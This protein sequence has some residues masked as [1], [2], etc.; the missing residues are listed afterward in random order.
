MESSR[1]KKRPRGGLR[2]R[3]KR[4]NEGIE[5]NNDVTSA[6]ALL[7]LSLFEWGFFSPQRVQQIAE[8][9][10]R[11]IKAAAEDPSILKNL[12]TLANLGTKGKHSN[13]I[14][15][16]L[17]SKVEHVPA[18]PRPFSAKIPLKGFPNSMQY[19]LL[20]HEMFSCIYHN[21]KNL[22][23]TA[24]VPSVDR[25]KKF[26]RSMRLHPS[27]QGHPM[28]ADDFWDAQTVPLA[29][30]GDGVPITGIGKVWSRVKTNY[31]WYSLLGHGNTASMLMWIW[32]FFDKLKVGNQT[33][34]TLHEFYTLLKWSFLALASG[35]WPS[36]DHRGVKKLGSL[37]ATFP[38]VFLFPGI[39]PKLRQPF[40]KFHQ[41][42]SSQS[43]S[44]LK[45]ERFEFQFEVVHFI[46]H[47]TIFPRCRFLKSHDPKGLQQI[48]KRAWKPT[49]CWLV[50]GKL[51]CGHW[52]VT[53]ITFAACWEPQ[54]I[55]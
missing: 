41:C 2:Q 44:W 11:D 15:A 29:V 20:P 43:L 53:W 49:H 36:H 33:E 47:E 45:V 48:Q 37:T 16:E 22:W 10:V 13:N 46:H 23:N 55:P 50:D 27:M 14:H 42:H 12:E 40:S 25:V 19:F 26:W 3:L 17:M 4:S 39:F 1:P 24:I 35:K 6:L 31:S 34:G 38:C 7:L 9:A 18:I 28:K 51:C 30:H 32:G 5:E 54:T 52:Q 8:M 21:Y